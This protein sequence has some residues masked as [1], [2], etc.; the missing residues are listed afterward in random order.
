M[1]RQTFAVAAV[2]VLAVLAVLAIFAGNVA[3]RFR[4]RDG[5]RPVSEGK[6][7]VTTQDVVQ[8]DDTLV[9]R[10]EIESHP[11]VTVR[12]TSDIPG[13]GS[14]TVV[15]PAE[16]APA[17]PVRLMVFGD[18][19]RW[20]A[21]RVDALKFLMRLDGASISDTG[22]VPPNMAKLSEVLSITARSGEH[23]EG[24]P[25]P[26]VTLKGTAYSLVVERSQR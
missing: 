11:G 25:I 4:I 3:D 14:L 13:R 17:A 26:V 18:H 8:D 20:E 23:P 10:I 22:S 6:F 5:V 21:G 24:D 2:A 19:V 16:P 1:R 9:C 7:R 15:V 12:I